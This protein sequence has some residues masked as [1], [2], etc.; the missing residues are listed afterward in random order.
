MQTPVH[1]TAE[2]WRLQLERERPGL[3]RLIG[4]I[5]W[6]VLVVALVCEVPQLLVLIGGAT[7]ADLDPPFMLPAGANFA[8]GLAALA[9]ALERA[10]RFKSSRW[11]G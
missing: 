11:L 5:A 7:G 8:L 10:L 2:A 3:S 6:S 1:G 9:A 4:A